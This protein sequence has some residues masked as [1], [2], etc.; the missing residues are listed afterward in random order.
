MEAVSIRMS[1]IIGIRG[2]LS[3]VSRRK[4]VGVDDQVG[5]I[6]RICCDAG[7]NNIKTI[8]SLISESGK[9]EWRC[10]STNGV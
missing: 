6:G 4:R 7:V 10:L 3:N 1:I 9:R 5:R 2:I 8:H